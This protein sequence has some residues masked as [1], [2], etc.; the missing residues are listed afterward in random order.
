MRLPKLPPTSIATRLILGLVLFLVLVLAFQSWRLRRAYQAAGQLALEADTLRA[1]RDT[2]RV[3]Q[4]ALVESL[5]VAQRQAIQTPQRQ[6]ALDKALKLQR[7][8]LAQLQVQIQALKATA[9]SAQ[10]TREDSSTGARTGH[11]D[12]RQQ[13]YTVAADVTLPR[14]P[15]RG[16]LEIQVRVDSAQLELRLG[17]AK[18]NAQGIRSAQTTV[19]GPRWLP[20]RLGRVEQSAEV[21]QSP[22]LARSSSASWW[23]RLEP[24]LSAGYGLTA[25]PGGQI[26]HG[27]QLGA[28]IDLWR[29]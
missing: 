22:A 28:H 9:S 29:P 27:V 24:H 12:I 16:Q 21:C 7:V 23:R 13:P 5:H 14:P 19:T 25:T 4:L 17:C 1:S 6:D 26:V 8:A 3:L 20:V 2:S 10:P 15:G 11:F 18:A